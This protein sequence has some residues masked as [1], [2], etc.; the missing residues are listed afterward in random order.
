MIALCCLRP[1]GFLGV[2]F[3]LHRRGDRRKRRIS[4]SGTATLWLIV[5]PSIHGRDRVAGGNQLNEMSLKF[6]HICPFSCVGTAAAS[7][8][9]EKKK[10]KKEKKKKEEEEEEEEGGMAATK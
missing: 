3:V 9:F 6:S 8:P 1:W 5:R 2:L 10:E 4:L 7:P